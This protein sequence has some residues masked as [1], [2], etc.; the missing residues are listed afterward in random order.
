MLVGPQRYVDLLHALPGVSTNLLAERLTRLQDD[1]TGRE[2]GHGAP[3]RRSCLRA[4]RPGTGRQPVILELLRWGAAAADPARLDE[5]AD[6]SWPMFPLRWLADR[7]PTTRRI[8]AR[9][10][11]GTDR[12][13][14][15]LEGRS[16]ELANKGSPP[17]D[18]EVRAA[19][20]P[21]PRPSLGPRSRRPRP[22]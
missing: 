17:P 5:P 3:G 6:P 1:E 14:V 15:V 22:P 8:D 19:A 12:L 2:A 18:F 7:H 9:I 16:V 11:V 20:P 4:H 21:D 13:D 10:T